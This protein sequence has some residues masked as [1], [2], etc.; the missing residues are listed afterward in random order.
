M[1]A[2]IS[3]IQ[4]WVSIQHPIINTLKS[5]LQMFDEYPVENFHSL[6]RRH[7]FRKVTAG[8][9][10]RHDAIFIDYHRNDNEFAQTFASKRSYSYTKKEPGFDDKA[11]SNISFTIF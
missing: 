8:E 9:W 11:V 5:Y 6:V 3:D 10:L 4:Y 1:L 7:M 2:F